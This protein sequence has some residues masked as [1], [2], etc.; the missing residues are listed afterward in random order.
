MRICVV[1]AGAAGVELACSMYE[2]VR[3]DAIERV[4]NNKKNVFDNLWY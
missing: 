2:R 4:S 3:K 1:G